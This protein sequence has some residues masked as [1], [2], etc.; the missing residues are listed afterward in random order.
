MCQ[1]LTETI[2]LDKSKFMIMKE[3][4]NFHIVELNDS[5]EYISVKNKK[6][7]KGDVIG[8]LDTLSKSKD[9]DID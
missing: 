7:V 3:N 2:Y 9:V 4:S 1:Q 6:Y 8:N 5:V